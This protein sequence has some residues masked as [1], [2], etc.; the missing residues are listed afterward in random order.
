MFSLAELAACVGD[1]TSWT[2]AFEKCQVSHSCAVER[3]KVYSPAFHHKPSR[4]METAVIFSRWSSPSQDELF[5]VQEICA[6]HRAFAARRR[7]GRVVTWGSDSDGGDSSAVQDGGVGGARW[8]RLVLGRPFW[9]YPGP[10][11]R[12]RAQT[13]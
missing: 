11:D 6:T 7:D 10:K 9:P 1:E 8:T 2:L 12:R 13:R 4:P 5:E 3:P